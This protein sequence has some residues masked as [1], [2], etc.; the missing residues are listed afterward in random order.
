MTTEARERFLRL[1][2]ARTDKSV[3]A[4]RLLTRAVRKS[5]VQHTPE[6]ALACFGAIEAAAVEL[7]EALSLGGPAAAS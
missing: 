7:Y 3:T 2:P 6:E 1:N 5:Q 4:I